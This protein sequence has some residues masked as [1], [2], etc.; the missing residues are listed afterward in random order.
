MNYCWTTTKPAPG[1]TIHLATTDEGILRLD[2][3]SVQDAFLAGLPPA[4]W[5]HDKHH[6]LL[7]EAARQLAEYFHSTR[8][9]F[10]VPLDLRGTEFQKRIW[11]CL[12]Q[13]PYGETRSYAQLAECAGAPHAFRAAGQANGKN[14]VGIIVP[15]HRVIAANGSLGGFSCGVDYKIRLL[16]LEARNAWLSRA[17]ASTT[18]TPIR[19]QHK[20]KGAT[21]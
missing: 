2:M 1:W 9:A 12:Q 14:P 5:K 8:T 11:G 20:G 6:P 13:I 4:P 7:I 15:C 17:S 19:S 21:S 3:S 18:S 10:D 16:G